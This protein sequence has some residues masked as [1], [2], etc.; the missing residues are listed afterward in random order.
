M[1]STIT[2]I[3]LFFIITCFAQKPKNLFKIT[4]KINQTVT[5]KSNLNLGKKMNDLS[6]AWKSSNACFSATEQKYFNGNHVLFT[7]IIPKSTSY[8]LKLIPKKH[9]QNMSIYCYEIDVND[10]FLV[11]NLP[12]SNNC[13]AKT[14]QSI[15]YLKKHVREIKSKLILKNNTRLVI[16]V[17]G[18]NKLSNGDFTLLIRLTE[19]K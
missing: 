6:W 2:I 3:F 15:S 11:P 9:N 19:K 12:K 13:M 8:T 14:E 4:P 17:V 5:Y 10:N 7:G 18:A 1:R 16:G